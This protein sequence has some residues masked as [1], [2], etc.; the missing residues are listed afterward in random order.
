MSAQLSCR[1]RVTSQLSAE[2]LCSL[3]G[4]GETQQSNNYSREGDPSFLNHQLMGSSMMVQL[5]DVILNKKTR[6]NCECAPYQWHANG[7]R[8]LCVSEQ[9][10]AQ[11]LR[12]LYSVLLGGRPL[13]DQVILMIGVNDLLNKMP[14][15]PLI[16]MAYF[17]STM[18]P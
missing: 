1:L 3:G 17:S 5:A 9:K 6:R 11:L 18:E 2:A 7:P 12:R 13:N 14:C 15:G 16:F 8:V 4:V 10:L